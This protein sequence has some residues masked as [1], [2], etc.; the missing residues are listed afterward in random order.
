MCKSLFTVVMIVLTLPVIAFAAPGD[1]KWKY[2]GG[3]VVSS[4]PALGPDGSVYFGPEDGHLYSLT[5]QGSLKW[6]YQAGDW[7]FSCPAIG[8]EGTVYFG[9]W[10]KYLYALTPQGTLKWQYKDGNMVKCSPAV[11]NDGSVYFGSR[12]GSFYA[13]TSQGLLKWEYQADDWIASSPVV[14]LDDFVYFGSNYTNTIY[15]ANLYALNQDGEFRWQYHIDETILS[16]PAVDSDGT[17]YIGAADYCLY[18]LTPEGELKWKY[19]TG[20]ELNSSAAIGTDGSVYFGSDDGYFY[21]LNS[22]GLLKWKYLTEGGISSSPAIGAD[23]ILYFGSGDGF[24]YA[25]T[26]QGKL[27]WKI[28]T[29]GA[30]ISSPVISTD[31]TLYV[32]SCDSSLYAIECSSKGLAVTPWPKFRHDNRNTGCCSQGMYATTVVAPQETTCVHS[33][34]PAAYFTNTNAGRVKNFYC[35]CEIWPKNLDILPLL[36]PPYHCEYWISYTVEPGDSVLVEFSRWIS[37]NSS[38]YTARFYAT[39][40]FSTPRTVDFEGSVGFVENPQLKSPRLDVS[41]LLSEMVIAYSVTEDQ[42]ATIFLYDALGRLIENEVVQGSGS[43][44]FKSGLASGVYFVKLE[45]GCLSLTRK[46]A[47]LR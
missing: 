2:K 40:V 23:G 5:P 9:S 17:L 13:L 39:D 27:K 4:S 44:S 47:I 10:D 22:D 12:A 36:S 7:I 25:L 34:V 29:G 18:A 21:A 43:V 15:G 26:P 14:G 30:I 42:N 6:K 41:V 3:G 35:H 11:G 28:Q 16:S 46:T 37:D 38:A 1:F 33:I 45:T 31:G 24:L 20:G 32:G 19:S 8:S